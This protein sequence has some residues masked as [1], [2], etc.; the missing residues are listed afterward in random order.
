MAGEGGGAGA[1][2]MGLSAIGTIASSI[3]GA[4]AAKAQARAEA[5]AA[6]Y[7]AVLA[8]MEGNAEERR[9]RRYA[10][11]TLSSQFVQMAG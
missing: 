7:N 10:R 6:E 5:A 11:R 1:G 9:Q 4:S 2:L 3:M 8:E